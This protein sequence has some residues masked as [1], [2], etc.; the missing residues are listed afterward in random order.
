[1]AKGNVVLKIAGIL[2]IIFGIL[3]VLWTMQYGFIGAMGFSEMKREVITGLLIF[4]GLCGILV[5]FFQIAIG[6]IAVRQSKK[7]EHG[8]RCI[9]WGAIALILG[10]FVFVLLKVTSGMIHP[11]MA[12]ML[13]F[14]TSE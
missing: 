13:V 11:D 9:V 3:N 12:T 2:L 14:I 6:A 4:Y 5:G 7:P 8:T 10:I 1:M